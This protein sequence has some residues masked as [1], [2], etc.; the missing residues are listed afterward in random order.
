ME[1][2]T[3]ENLQSGHL[4]VD[5]DIEPPAPMERLTFRAYRNANYYNEQ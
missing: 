3:P 5:F 2:N 1:E 4:T